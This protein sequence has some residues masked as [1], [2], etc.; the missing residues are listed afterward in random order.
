MGMWVLDILLFGIIAAF[1]GYRLYQA[2]GQKNPG[3]DTATTNTATAPVLEGIARKIEPAAP[4][5]LAPT[6]VAGGMAQ[7][8]AADPRFDE[9]QFISGAT[10]AF[11]MILEAYAAGDLDVLTNL[12]SPELYEKF[13]ASITQR[14]GAAPNPLKMVEDVEI[15]RAELRGVNA[16]IQTRIRSQQLTETGATEEVV[17]RWTFG[18]DIRNADPR[19]LLLA[20]QT[21]A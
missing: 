17:D 15:I 11:K 6:S 12:L 16:I 18:R 3:D 19:W 20:T 1:F 2:L 9:K 10:N 7:I 4:L 14:L 13:S 5:T 21:G 8:S